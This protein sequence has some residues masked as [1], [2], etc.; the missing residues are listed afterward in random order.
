[1]HATFFLLMAWDV[2]LLKKLLNLLLQFINFLM[3]FKR[4]KKKNCG[5]FFMAPLDV[6]PIYFQYTEI[7]RL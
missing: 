2:V 1:M 7:R 3:N 5:K 4:L 6:V